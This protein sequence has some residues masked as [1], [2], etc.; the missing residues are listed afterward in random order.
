MPDGIRLR[1]DFEERRKYANRFNARPALDLPAS[2]LILLESSGS[3]SASSGDL[4]SGE[5]E[6]LQ[7]PDGEPFCSGAIAST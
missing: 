7:L 5:Y 2:V 3:R 1:P 6:R 4:I